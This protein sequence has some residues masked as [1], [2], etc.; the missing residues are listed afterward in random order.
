MELKTHSR[1]VWQTVDNKY[2]D[3][4]QVFL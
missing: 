3:L 2:K 4:K 1:G